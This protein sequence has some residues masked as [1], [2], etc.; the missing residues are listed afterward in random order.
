MD[1][2]VSGKIRTMYVASSAIHS[3]LAR[4]RIEDFVPTGNQTDLRTTLRQSQGDRFPDPAAG[5]SHDG[6][7]TFQRFHEPVSRS[8][9]TRP[10]VTVR[11]VCATVLAIASS[12]KPWH[13]C[14]YSCLPMLGENAVATPF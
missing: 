12:V 1:V 7:L 6:E 14:M 5:S 9:D 13:C 2:F 3:G 8:L 11:K 4:N 10:L